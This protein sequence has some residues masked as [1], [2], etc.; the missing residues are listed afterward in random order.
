MKKIIK[1]GLKITLYT[2]GWLI[3][4]VILLYAGYISLL[5]ADGI[6]GDDGVATGYFTKVDAEGKREKKYTQMW[7]NPVKIINLK[8]K[9][10]DIKNWTIAYPKTL[11]E[12]TEHF[13]TVIMVNGTY[14][15]ASD[16]LPVLEHLASWGFIVVGNEDFQSG[17]GESTALTLDFLLTLAKDKTS[18]FYNKIDLEHIGVNGHS[19]GGAGA[20][21][22]ITNYENGKYYTSLYTVSPIPRNLAQHVMKPYDPSKI[23]IPYFMTSGLWIQDRI[24][25]ATYW[26]L[27]E[28]YDMLP[29][30][31][32]AIMA[33]R[34]EADHRD[35]LEYADAYMTAWFLMTLKS[36]Q[37]AQNV[38]IGE[39][40]ELFNTSNWQDT[41]IKGTP[42]K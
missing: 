18:I 21:N 9:N 38:F 40:A 13:P 15:P 35:M 24:L 26:T 16:Y 10:Q 41:S 31:T 32:F 1:T 8:S 2:L 12:K 6:T 37:E 28:N 34:K 17:S 33:R 20:I 14:T 23:K 25:I 30:S 27:K 7:P 19:Q 5:N 11:E 39:N 42:L 3:I 29:S 4:L 22:A 36:D